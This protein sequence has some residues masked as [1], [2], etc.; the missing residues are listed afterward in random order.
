MQQVS[1]VILFYEKE[2]LPHERSECANPPS[3]KDTLLTSCILRFYSRFKL[4][5]SC[6]K[7]PN[8]HT[9]SLKKLLLMNEK[10]YNCVKKMTRYDTFFN[11]NAKMNRYGTFFNASWPIQKSHIL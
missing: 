9:N 8:L 11:L 5:H 1:K 3:K 7:N 2:N 4:A 6:Q 10:F